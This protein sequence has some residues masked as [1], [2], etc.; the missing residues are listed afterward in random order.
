M[1]ENMNAQELVLDDV[2]D[3]WFT[4]FWQTPVGY[5]ILIVL[6]FALLA[7]L[8]VIFKLLGAR[9]G[10]TKE[11]SLRSLRALAEKYKKGSIETKKVYQELTGTIKL[12]TQWRYDLPRGMTDYE[13]TALLANVD[14]EKKRQDDVRRIVTDAQMI[15]FGRVEALKSQ[16]Q[17][18]IAAVVTFIEQTAHRK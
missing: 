4:P 13:L 6:V 1:R 18:D 16:V 11:Q 7:L 5:G 12:Y 17:H 10:S 15:K 2:Y 3:V 8:Y 14:C 9:R